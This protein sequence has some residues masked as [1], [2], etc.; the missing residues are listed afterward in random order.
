MDEKKARFLPFH[1]INEFMLDEYRNQVLQIALSGQPRPA[2][3]ALIKRFVQVPG[4]RNS[5]QA[6]LALKVRGLAKAFQTNP[7]VAAQVLLAW[8]D[9]HGELC[10]QVADVLHERGWEFLPSE[11]DRTKLPGFL[12]VWPKDET[13]ETLIAAYRQKYPD[14]TVHDYD[15]SL[16][17]VWLS[18][19]LPVDV[20]DQ[21]EI[22]AQDEAA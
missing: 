17:A 12:T 4:F 19:R 20:Q 22:D 13:F 1:A 6:P 7:E 11:A 15:I 9:A 2:L 8:A 18:G 5:T 10:D 3:T 21:P 16:M 14:A